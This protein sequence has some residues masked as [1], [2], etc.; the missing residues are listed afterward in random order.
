MHITITLPH[1]P[2]TTDW[3]WA[4]S[5]ARRPP[6]GHRGRPERDYR[7]PLRPPGLGGER[8]AYCGQHWLGLPAGPSRTSCTSLSHST[9]H[10]TLIRTPATHRHFATP[11][12]T[13]GQGGCGLPLHRH[14][15]TPPLRSTQSAHRSH[16][17]FT[18]PPHIHRCKYLHLVYSHFARL[19]ARRCP[20]AWNASSLVFY[21]VTYPMSLSAGHRG[22]PRVPYTGCRPRHPPVL[23]RRVRCLLWRLT[24][25]AFNTVALTRSA[26]RHARI[27]LVF[28]KRFRGIY[29]VTSWC[30]DYIRPFL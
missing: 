30:A 12:L 24:S 28:F 22:L 8:G 7:S 27:Q 23:D 15:H 6:R 18:P 17:T 20:N 21:S 25:A 29:P 9:T 19:A 5:G 14:H 10:F 1:A 13:K 16:V 3:D 2:R 4:R 11:T 26:F